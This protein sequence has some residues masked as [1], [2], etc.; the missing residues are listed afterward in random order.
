M[1]KGSNLT[2]LSINFVQYKLVFGN[3]NTKKNNAPCEYSLTISLKKIKLITE[4]NTETPIRKRPQAGPIRERGSIHFA[5]TDDPEL[6]YKSV[7]TIVFVT[8]DS[9]TA[10]I[11]VLQQHGNDYLFFVFPSTSLSFS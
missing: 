3:K 8:Y 7:L 11:I 5:I 2:Q 6:I 10:K 9:N 4:E 1:E